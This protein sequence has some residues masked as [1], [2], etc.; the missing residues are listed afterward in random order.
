MSI[1]AAGLAV[2]T[3]ILFALAPVVA[4]LLRSP[5]ISL[6]DATRHIAGLRRI[7]SQSVLIVGRVALSL[8]LV[9][10]G[11]WLSTSLW[12][13]FSRPVGFDTDNLITVYTET[14]RDRSVQIE[15]AR[16][17]VGRLQQLEPGSVDRVAASSGQLPGVNASRYGPHRIRADQPAFTDEN[18]P[19]LSRAAVSMSYFRVLGIPILRGRSFTAEDERNPEGVVI[20][21]RS[22]AVRW[23]PDGALGQS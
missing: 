5:S 12:R 2:V 17:A 1:A 23:F 8:V 7:R 18:Q 6:R 10:S 20:A 14:T 22:F 19:I 4:G 13:T 15:M 9:A 16:R 21:S 3:S 11:V